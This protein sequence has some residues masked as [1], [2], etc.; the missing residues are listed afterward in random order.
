MSEEKA[1]SPRQGQ[2]STDAS[3]VDDE[4][5]ADTRLGFW[6]CRLRQR[7]TRLARLAS[8][9]AVWCHTGHQKI[10]TRAR[11]EAKHRS[12]NPVRS[13]INLSLLFTNRLGLAGKNGRDGSTKS[14]PDPAACQA[15]ED[16][17]HGGATA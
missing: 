5:R 13:K 17:S 1:R 9:D 11:I 10:R 12:P 4:W 14:N 16:A 15:L 6:R 7:A 8:L 2:V 3:L